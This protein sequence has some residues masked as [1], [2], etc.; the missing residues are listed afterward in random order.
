MERARAVRGGEARASAVTPIASLRRGHGSS[1]RLV[2]ATPHGRHPRPALA[3]NPRG[4][5]TSRGRV[6]PATERAVKREENSGAVAGDAVRGPCTAMPDRGEP[7]ERAV[8]HVARRAAADVRDEAD[9]ARIAFACMGRTEAAAGRRRWRAPF[10]FGGSKTPAAFLFVASAAGREG[11]RRLAGGAEAENRGLAARG[12][13]SDHGCYGTRHERERI[14]GSPDGDKPSARTRIWRRPER[15][16]IVTS[17]TR[18]S[19][20]AFP[21]RRSLVGLALLLPR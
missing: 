19:R 6:G 21:A 13:E 12:C 17:M 11:E 15:S 10:Y 3:A 8:E 20:A 16:V 18:P 14:V 7:G 5:S 4:G 1:S 9:A 2:R